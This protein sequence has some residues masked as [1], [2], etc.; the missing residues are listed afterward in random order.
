MRKWKCYLKSKEDTPPLPTHWSESDN[1]GKTCQKGRWEGEITT[2]LQDLVPSRLHC[3]LAL[4]PMLLTSHFWFLTWRCF[5]L[6]F[7]PYHQQSW[8]I[9][10]PQSIRNTLRT[11]E[12]VSLNW[13]NEKA[14]EKE[15]WLVAGTGLAAVGQK[16]RTGYKAHIS[17][18]GVRRGDFDDDTY[19]W[20]Q[21]LEVD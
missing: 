7:S 12:E 6:L 13:M 9:S 10:H 5:W 14:N 4:C 21:E 2:S 8:I 20:G 17:P 3:T 18:H 11:S 15:M 19:S 1:P 16:S